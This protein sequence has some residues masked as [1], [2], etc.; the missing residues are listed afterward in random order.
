MK[1]WRYTKTVA[2]TGKS[3][4]LIWLVFSTLNTNY[5]LFPIGYIRGNKI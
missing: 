5:P 4:G 1:F 2:N 3:Y